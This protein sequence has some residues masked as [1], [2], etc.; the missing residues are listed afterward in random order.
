MSTY[1]ITR[2]TLAPETRNLGA[3]LADSGDADAG[4]RLVWTLFPDPA[5]QRDFVYREAAKGIYFIVSARPAV[6][7]HKLW[8][9]DCQPYEP[10]PVAGSR[11]SFILRAN[12][13]MDISRNNAR[14]MRVD[15]VMHAKMK[16]KER[17]ERW[18]ADA[19]RQA[20]L[21]WLF[22]REAEIGVRFNR[23]ACDASG[24]QQAVIAPNRTARDRRAIRHSM[25]DYDGLLEVVDGAK[26]IEKLKHG[27]GR[28]RAFGCGLML[29]RRAT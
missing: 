7:Q 22:R 16:A 25:I 14:S 19:E 12:P 4:H 18:S 10:E 24:Y 8:H 17:G 5:G 28:A 6:D 27:I 13:S 3:L 20:A 21:D 26:F 9:L 23:E 2:A 11:Y 15:A 1:H 29:I